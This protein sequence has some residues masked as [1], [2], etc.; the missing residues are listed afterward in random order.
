V[1]YAIHRCTH[2]HGD[3]LPEGFELLADAAGEPRQ[4]RILI[5][6]GRVR[7]S[8]RVIFGLLAVAVLAPA[9]HD[10]TVPDGYVLTFGANR[11]LPIRDWWGRSNEFLSVAAEDPVPLVKLDFD[12]WM[13]VA[14]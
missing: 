5:E 6:K 4:T 9:N 8:D 1:I 14:D 11:V 3:E 13:E 10:Q 2:G 12:D 7:L